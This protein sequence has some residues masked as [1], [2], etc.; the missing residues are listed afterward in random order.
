MSGVV[1]GCSL[2]FGCALNAAFWNVIVGRARI[3]R[4]SNLPVGVDFGHSTLP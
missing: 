3:G 1:P 4:L 2:G